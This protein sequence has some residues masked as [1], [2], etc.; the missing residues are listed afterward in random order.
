MGDVQ[1]LFGEVPE[2][3]ND[4]PPREVSFR[5]VVELKFADLSKSFIGIDPKAT[6]VQLPTGAFA[7]LI[8]Q[9]GHARGA[10]KD[11][12]LALEFLREQ[13]DQLP[14]EEFANVANAFAES[15]G[16]HIDK[17]LGFDETQV[18]LTPETVPA[19]FENEVIDMPLCPGCGKPS[20]P[21]I[22]TEFH[23]DISLPMFASH[24]FTRKEIALCADKNRPKVTP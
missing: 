15:T 12:E 8:S 18:G 17:S 20:S 2:P 11:I 24:P 3:R 13:S 7:F 22:T 5:D 19:E 14:A 23:C 21:Y 4:P 1:N 6:H 10:L 16:E 9:L